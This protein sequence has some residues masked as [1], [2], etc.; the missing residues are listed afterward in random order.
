[1][2]IFNSEV[3]AKRTH[4]KTGSSWDI[5]DNYFFSYFILEPDFNGSLIYSN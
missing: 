2:D 4:P 5:Q 3:P 1:M